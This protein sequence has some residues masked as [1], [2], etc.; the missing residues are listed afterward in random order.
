MQRSPLDG[1]TVLDLTI[2]QNGPWATVMLSDMGANVIKIEDP[3]KG[4]PGRNMAAAGANVTR[5]VSHYFQ[6][7]NRNKRSM[8]LNLKHP[9]GKMLFLEMAKKADVVVQNFRVG[10][11]EKLGIDYE[12]VKKVNPKIIYASVSGFGPEGPDAK[13]GVFDILGQGRGGLL[14]LLNL[15]EAEPVYRS[16]AGLSDQTGAITL[17]YGLLLAI[18]AR[19]RFGVGQHMQTSQLGGQLMLQALAINSFLMNGDLPPARPRTQN[20]NPLFNI[21]KCGDEKWVA[22]GCVQSD[23]WWP[24]VCN[25]LGLNAIRDDP[26]FATMGERSKNCVEVIKIMDRT[27]ATKTRDEWLKLLK[28]NAVICGPVQSYADLPNDPQVIANHYLTTVKH[29]VHGDLREVGV[30]VKLSETPGYARK[31]APEFGEHTEEVL[32][33]FGFGWDKIA[34]LREQGAI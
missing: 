14:W 3:D 15:G 5:K 2:W 10:V 31:T 23:R 17:A 13:D 22:L 6:T 7:M 1:I 11:V 25:A 30:P 26:R 16:Y 27:F 32:Q 19:E 21:Y 20:G 28:A 34:K 4:D 8:T 9:E 29:P 33:E 12:S 24:G 18:I